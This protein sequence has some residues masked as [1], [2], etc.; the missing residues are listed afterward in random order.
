MF[1]CLHY[2]VQFPDGDCDLLDRATNL[3]CRYAFQG[4]CPLLEL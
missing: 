3:T 4:I 1:Q 2:N